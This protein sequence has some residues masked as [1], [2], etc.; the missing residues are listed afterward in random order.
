M[1]TSIVRDDS[2]VVLKE[3]QHLIVPII[4]AER[5]S[6]MENNRL[7]IPR[8]PVLEEEFGPIIRFDRRHVLLRR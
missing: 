2:E 3:E 4:R 7:R 8:T 6:M 5:P 1:A